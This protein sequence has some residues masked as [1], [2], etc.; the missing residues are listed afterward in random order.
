MRRSGDPLRFCNR[1]GIRAGKTQDRRRD[2]GTLSGPAAALVS[3]VRAVLI[4]R[5]RTSAERWEGKA[6]SKSSSR[7]CSSQPDVC[8]D[9]VK[10]LLERDKVDFV[11]G[12]IFSKTSCRQSKSRGPTPRPPDQPELPASRVRRAK[13]LPIRLF[14]G[15]LSERQ[16]HGNFS[17]RSRQDRATSAGGR[18]D[19]AEYQAGKVSVAG[20]KL[21]TRAEIVEE[22]YMP[23]GSL[24]F[25]G[26]ALPRS[27]PESLTPSRIHLCPRLGRTLV[28][29]VIVRVGLA[30]KDLRCFRPFH[31][32][33]ST[34]PGPGSAGCAIGMFGPARKG[35]P[36]S[37]IRT[38][39]Q[40][41]RGRDE[42]DYNSGRNLCLPGYDAAMM[43]DSEVQGGEGRDLA[44]KDAV[45]GGG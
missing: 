33:E 19:G 39:K 7:R 24:A 37:T 32:D 9:Q 16:V 34:L 36:I 28:K 22:P 3:S 42:A 8:G 30:D 5:S 43:I 40:R 17:A 25:P 38:T 29:A 1:P 14:Y 12:P 23:W 15:L 6:T 26:R 13:E 11:A 21:D 18:S 45:G 31:G 20:L 41:I 2:R 44:N 35:H 4:S 10:G 27:R